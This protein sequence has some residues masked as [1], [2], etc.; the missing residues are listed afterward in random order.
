MFYGRGAGELPTA[1][2]IMGDV[3]DVARDIRYQCTGRISCTCYRDTPVK[4]F[5]DVKNKFFLRMQVDNKPGVLAAIASVFGV[6]KVSI[7]KV[8]QKVITDGMA[9][10]VIVTEAVKEYHMEDAI[11]HLKD[12]DTT[13]EISSVIREY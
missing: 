10:L 12:M 5:K 8:I 13:R 11:E 6:H 7:S 2:A 9:E 1:S 4:E 3:I